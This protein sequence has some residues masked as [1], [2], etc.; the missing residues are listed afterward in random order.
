MTNGER[1]V[2]LVT[3]GARGIGA[4]IVRQAAQQGYDLCI[5]YLQNENA[6]DQLV[7][8]LLSEGHRAIAVR[9]DIADPNAV[10]DLFNNAESFLGPIT[11]LVNNAGITGPIGRF[12]NAEIGTLR[13]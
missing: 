13:R 12:Q 3:G 2:M 5:N 9:G 11:F 7:K 1:K 6:A 4:A 8:E 10:A